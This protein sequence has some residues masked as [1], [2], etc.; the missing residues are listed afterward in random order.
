MIKHNT[1]RA[2]SIGKGVMK[3][4]GRA[5]AWTLMASMA[6]AWMVDR[7]I[8]KLEHTGYAAM[9]ILLVCGLFLGKQAAPV[10]AKERLIGA[11]AGTGLYYLCLLLVNWLFFGGVTKGLWIMLL[12]LLM[13]TA[14]GSI[15]P[16]R[17]R[18]GV[19]TRRYK[20]PKS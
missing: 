11:A 19:P 17:G 14:L 16:R 5:T 13:G 7:E 6:T 12:I 4:L 20:I 3:G 10:T 2:P 9:A 18:G 8:M 1:G 15:Q